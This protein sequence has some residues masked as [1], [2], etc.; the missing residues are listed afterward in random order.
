M[1]FK[2]FKS[3]F[4]FIPLSLLILIIICLIV[5][6]NPVF[7]KNM[8]LKYAEPYTDALSIDKV[9]LTPWSLKLVNL[10]AEYQ[11]SHLLLEESEIRFCITD[12]LFKKINVKKI[13]VKQLLVNLENQQTQAEQVEEKA[14]FPGVLNLINQG[15]G[16]VLGAV[17]VEAQINLPDQQKLYLNM[18]GGEV[19]PEQEGKLTTT[20]K[21]ETGKNEDHIVINNQLLLD[22]LSQGKF[23]KIESLIDLQLFLADLPIDE[24]IKLQ[25]II[26][27]IETTKTVINGEKEK[28]IEVQNDNITI[29]LNLDQ[30]DGTE[31]SII[32]L[33]AVYDTIT[34]NINGN[35]Q[36]TANEK[37]IQPYIPD[38]KLPTSVQTLQGN[39]N[40]L[41]A[42]NTGD[43][44]ILGELQLDK[45]QSEVDSQKVPDFLKIKNN[46]R[47]SM[48]P[49]NQLKISVLEAGIVDDAAKDSLL[50]HSP[51]EMTVPLNDIDAFLAQDNTLLEIDVPKIPLVWFDF[52]IP[53]YEI[54]DGYFST[55][56]KISTKSDSSI[57]L[58]SL[59]PL[60]VDS[61][62]MLQAGD[63]VAENINITITP[64][65]SYHQTKLALSLT[66]L[67]V[68]ANKKFLIDGDINTS[69]IFNTEKS[70]SIALAAN[71]RV[72]TENTLA[73][74]DPKAKYPQDI[75]G[76]FSTNLKALVDL[77]ED[78]M[79]INALNLNVAGTKQESLIALSLLQ[80]IAVSTLDNSLTIP[81]GNL[82]Q[83]ALSDIKL[84]WLTAFIPE[85]DARGTIQQAN[86]NLAGDNQ[87]NASLTATSPLKISGISIYQNEKALIDDVNFSVLPVI[88]LSGREI[89]IEYS[90]LLIRHDNQY[91]VEGGGQLTIPSTGNNPLTTVGNLKLDLQAISQQ[92]LVAEIMQG[93]IT[94][95]LRLNASYALDMKADSIHISQL[96]STLHYA[97]S[98][99][100]ITLI[101]DSDITIRTALSAQDHADLAPASGQVT[102]TIS[103]LDSSPFKDILKANHLDFQQVN[104]KFKLISNGKQFSVDSIE[105]LKVTGVAIGSDQGAIFNPFS[106]SAAI[107]I[108]M[109]N[110][111]AHLTLDN[112]SM[113]MNQQASQD[114]INAD[115]MLN[116]VKG[117]DDQLALHQLNANIAADLPILLGQPVLLPGHKLKKGKADIEFSLLPNRNLQSQIRVHALESKKTLPLE[118]TTIKLDG[119]WYQDGRFKVAGP[120][121]TKGKTGESHIDAEFEATAWQDKNR[122]LH[123]NLVSD[124]FYLNDI[125][126][127]VNNIQQAKV[128]SN[129]DSDSNES[130]EAVSPIDEF[131]PDQQAF[132]DALPYQ[133]NISFKIDE[134]FYTDYLIINS[135]EG[136][137]R[138][139]PEEMSIN[140][141]TASFHDSPLNI[142]SNMKFT[143]G[144]LPYDLDF[145][146]SITQFDLTTFL[147]ELVPDAKPRAEGLFDISLDASGTSP[148][149]AQY[150]NELLFDMRLQSKDGLFRLLDPD[151]ALI[152]GS[153]KFLGAV[154]EGISYVPTGLF[155][156][157]AVS[158]LVKYIKV[159]KYDLIDIHLLRDESRNFV[160]EKYRVENPELLMTA[161]GGVDYVE[162]KDVLASPLAMDAK[163]SFRGHG[164]AIM[165]D[166]N[167]LEEEQNSDGYWQGPEISFTGTMTDS[168]SNLDEVISKAGTAAIL[169]GI[170]RPISG[171][172]GNIKYRWFGNDEKPPAEDEN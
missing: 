63:I 149:I 170:T 72:N 76:L 38:Q 71:T 69:V 114:V 152:G 109:D 138:L 84:N 54:T 126:N 7:Q 74:I 80:S 48:L 134:L 85:V 117:K 124:A 161:A 145:D 67:R 105:P 163:L 3:P 47:I 122:Q 16:Y 35:Y 132:W 142:N 6:F 92:P 112:Y 78:V 31:R 45:L 129:E 33:Q 159:I 108:N 128:S 43:V 28:Q 61:F 87:R 125:L 101:A 157:G 55:A 169:G 53:D 15:F 5:L 168:K 139:S 17:F 140:N 131:A 82:A 26:T 115:I 25:A 113:V 1:Q 102:L 130:K 171:L 36:L 156:V 65:I 57:H 143:A 27:P 49:D 75:P 97:D 121:S 133:S 86:F 18:Q 42:N 106:S 59:K 24:Q 110:A 154:G 40:Y 32:N 167:L 148:N 164:A 91:L 13:E 96:E 94:S 79:T 81:A 158:R 99:P 50:A 44:T 58:E 29:Q 90:D 51:Q 100:R 153:T 73:L 160:I 141:F 137:A 4:V 165:Y 83:L 19:A 88:R 147:T 21:F 37:L 66:D 52:L 155:G 41:L 9:H 10:N 68:T 77:K 2:R 98:T 104:G 56:F 123:M 34:E 12:F 14:P 46:F 11:G 127:M 39:F 118:E 111:S 8:L 144:K 162:G 120:I 146:A 23:N 107:S 70:N 166:L 135:I 64:T 22:Q 172:I 93:D 151:S 119:Q 136:Q 20:L 62:A 89:A 103:E 60:I 150:R 116:I 95:A 30:E